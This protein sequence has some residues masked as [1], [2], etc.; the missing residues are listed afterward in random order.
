MKKLPKK[1]LKEKRT[2]MN[3]LKL[4]QDMNKI[5]IFSMPG[6]NILIRYER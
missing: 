4:M 5:L 3:A 1:Y 2:H 6:T